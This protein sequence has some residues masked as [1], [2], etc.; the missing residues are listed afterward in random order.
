M[1]IGK[2]KLT[3]YGKDIKVRLLELGMTQTSLAEKIGCSSGYLN[4]ILMGD[5]KG[6]KY[7]D[8]IEECIGVV[9]VSEDK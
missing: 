7:Y 1:E 6:K 2:N 4:R 9:Y 5:R 8:K 3:N